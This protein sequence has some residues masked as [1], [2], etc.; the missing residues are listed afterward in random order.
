MHPLFVGCRGWVGWR[1]LRRWGSGLLIFVYSTTLGLAIITGAT[2]VKWAIPLI[3]GAKLG[4]SPQEPY[5]H[6]AP[7]HEPT[8]FHHRR[9]RS[10][11]TFL[12]RQPNRRCGRCRGPVPG[13]RSGH[14]LSEWPFGIVL[15]A[16]TIFVGWQFH[17]AAQL[18][19]DFLQGRFAPVFARQKKQEPEGRGATLV[20]S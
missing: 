3:G 7:L 8:D 9:P 6:L 4:R 19:A 12:P 15:C 18:T 20:V 1:S 14:H 11:A 10:P 13:E 16:R 2:R 5:Q 17:G